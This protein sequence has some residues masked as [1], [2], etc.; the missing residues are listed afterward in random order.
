V[1]KDKYIEKVYYSDAKTLNSY[2]IDK[3]NEEKSV[4]LSK[5]INYKYFSSFLSKKE[6][7]NFV[8]LFDLKDNYSTVFL[9][10]TTKKGKTFLKSAHCVLEN[11]YNK[12]E[13]NI[14]LDDK[15]VYILLK[16]LNKKYDQNLMNFLSNNKDKYITYIGIS[17]NRDLTLYYMDS[18]NYNKAKKLRNSV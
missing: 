3:D 16:I 9:N 6:Y 10:Y 17:Y 8:Q 12:N 14:N 7:N 13:E 2:K 15:R 4:Y 1:G 18:K 11:M 5:S